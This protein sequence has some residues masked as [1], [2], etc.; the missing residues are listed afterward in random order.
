MAR[1]TTKEDLILSAKSGFEK[2]EKVLNSLTEEEI[3]GTFDW[4]GQK[5]GKEAHW[6]RDKSVKDVLIHLYE[7]HVLLIDWI[8]SNM[9]GNTTSFLPSPYNWRTYGQMNEEFTKK[10][11]NTTYLEAKNDMERT[12]KEIMKRIQSFNNDELFSKGYFSW[13]G[14]TTLGSYCVSTTSSHYDW[15]IKKI[16]KYKK[17]LK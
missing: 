16:N 8:D 9:A 2:L 5:I 12:H 10:H 1:P 11:D 4:N 14:G 15:A 13:T 7:W 17:S 3:N 6:N